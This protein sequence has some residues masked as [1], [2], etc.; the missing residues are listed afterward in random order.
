MAV[1]EL[2]DH[3]PIGLHW[4]VKPGLGFAFH[5]KGAVGWTALP[6]AL[7]GPGKDLPTY[8]L[9]DTDVHPVPGDQVGPPKQESV[10]L[11]SSGHRVGSLVVGTDGVLRF[12]WNVDRVRSSGQIPLKE[13]VQALVR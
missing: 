9:A 1:V 2:G 12:L 7:A 8:A 6:M 5:A 11:A 10:W 4:L 3:V 13:C